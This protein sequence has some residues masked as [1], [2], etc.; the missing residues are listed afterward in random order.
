MLN[1]GRQ[2]VGQGKKDLGNK[3]EID[4][5]NGKLHIPKNNAPFTA[6]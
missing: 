2:R 1:I 3:I 6:Y 5:N 4:F